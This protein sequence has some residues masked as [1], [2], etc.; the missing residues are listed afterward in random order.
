MSKTTK[1]RPEMLDDLYWETTK[2]CSVK[3]M[4]YIQKKRWGEGHLDVR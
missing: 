3:R 1:M 2:E 4:K